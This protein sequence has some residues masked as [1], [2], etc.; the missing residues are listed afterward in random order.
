MAILFER[1]AVIGVGLIGGSLS[2]AAREAGLFGRVTGVGRGAANLE[3][4][5]ARGIVDRTPHPSQPNRA[6]NGGPQMVEVSRDGRRIYFTNSLYTPWDK[7][8]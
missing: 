7:Q 4:A 6:L 2:L 5:L 3:T 8:F 1:V